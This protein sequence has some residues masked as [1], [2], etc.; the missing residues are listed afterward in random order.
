MAQ[1]DRIAARRCS[2]ACCP[3]ALP[4][5]EGAEMAARYVPGAGAVG[6]DWYDV[7]TLP[8]GSWAW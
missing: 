1:E 5:T 3:S 2:A 7:F 4:A 6:G 8:L